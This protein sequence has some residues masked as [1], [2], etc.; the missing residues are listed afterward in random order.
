[1]ESNDELK[2][3]NIKNRT[4]YYFDEV[5]KIEDCD[6][7]NILFDGKWY[8]NILVYKHFIYHAKPLLTRFDKANGFVRIYDG[9]RYL[10]LFCPEKY[11][12]VYDRIRYL[13]G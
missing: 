11:D 1:M 2:E 13:I 7:D 8:K 10:V 5:I 9:T 6:F 12:A 3:I 4:C